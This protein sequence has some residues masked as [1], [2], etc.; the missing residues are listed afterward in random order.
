MDEIKKTHGI[1]KD[2]S[3]LD[4]ILGSGKKGKS[5]IGVDIGTSSI[6]VVQMRRESGA[7]VLETYGELALGPYA[8]GE[9][10]TATNL[11]AEKIAESLKDLLREANITSKDA[12]ISIP[13]SRSLMKLIE[14]PRVASAEEQRTM[15]QLEARKYIPVPVTEVQLDWFIVPEY[16]AP[17]STPSTKVK[18]LVVAVHNDELSLLQTVVT[19]A[20]VLASFYELEI[21]STIRAVVD[22]PVR[23]VLILDIGASATKV[24]IAEQGVIAVSHSITL[25]GQDVTR[26]IASATGVPLS[27]AEQLKL[28]QGFSSA[29]G[30]EKKTVELVYSRIFSDAKRVLIQYEA[31]HKKAIGVLYLT[32]GGGITKELAA[33]ASAFFNMEV[34]IGDPFGKTTAPAFMRPVLAEIGPGFAV[35]VGLALRKLEEQAQ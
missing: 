18:V 12:G 27:K 22:E 9:I 4:S 32:G 8:G 26:A 13:F 17:G 2:M 35:A 14:L 19:Q 23:P 28:E 21:F 15:I 34:R 6:K 25:G 1:M 24:Y 29:Q 33:Y 10:G 30:Y 7:A 16:S 31:I 20:G 3:F 11:P 5:V